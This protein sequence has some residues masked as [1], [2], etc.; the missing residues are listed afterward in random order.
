MNYENQTVSMSFADLVR[1]TKND[2]DMLHISLIRLKFAV[3]DTV[4]IVITVNVP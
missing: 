4:R 2:Q 3:V 1:A